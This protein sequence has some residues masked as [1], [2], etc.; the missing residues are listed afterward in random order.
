MIRVGNIYLTFRDHFSVVL[1]FYLFFL[2]IQTP[3]PDKDRNDAECFADNRADRKYPD[4][5]DDPRTGRN[6]TETADDAGIVMTECEVRCYHADNRQDLKKCIDDIE[7]F[8]ENGEGQDIRCDVAAEKNDKPW[9]IVGFEFVF[10]EEKDRTNDRNDVQKTAA[11]CADHEE[12]DRKKRSAEKLE[13]DNNFAA[14]LLIGENIEKHR[15]DA[16]RLC[17][18]LYCHKCTVLIVF[19]Y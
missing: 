8:S 13:H 11:E 2:S 4:V 18:H 15:N 5:V 7:R 17:D 14:L 19:S 1:Y 10:F 9:N 3:H 12:V 16:D 6:E